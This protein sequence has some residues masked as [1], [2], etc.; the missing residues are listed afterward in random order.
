MPYSFKFVLSKLLWAHS[1][2]FQNAAF[3]ECSNLGRRK[4]TFLLLQSITQ[5]LKQ[6]FSSKVQ[7]FSNAQLQNT[8]VLLFLSLQ[9]SLIIKN[10]YF[11]CNISNE[12]T[13]VSFQIS[14]K[15]NAKQTFRPFVNCNF[16]NLWCHERRKE[17]QN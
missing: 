7:F 1:K 14:Q 13:F 6:S 17:T 9:R 3:R 2:S 15:L 11:S 10:D 8:L 12:C 5:S 16:F 4:D